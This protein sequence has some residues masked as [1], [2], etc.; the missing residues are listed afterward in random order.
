M[1]FIPRLREIDEQRE[2][3]IYAQ[4]YGTETAVTK[5]KKGMNTPPLEEVPGDEWEVRDEADRKWYRALFDDKEYKRRPKEGFR[6]GWFHW[7]QS[8]DTAEERKLITKLDLLVCFY[9]FAMYW[10]KFL[11]QSNLNN[12]YVSGMKEELDMKGDDLIHTQI[13]YTVRAFVFFVLIIV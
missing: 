12:A 11:D 4:K 1:R 6:A 7:F 9:A 13:M 2:A 3:A 10:V 5:E 8:N